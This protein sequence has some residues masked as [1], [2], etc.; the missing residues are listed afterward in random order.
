MHYLLLASDYFPLTTST[1]YLLPNPAHPCDYY[2]RHHR[3]ELFTTQP[4]HPPVT[5]TT[6]TARRVHSA[7]STVEGLGLFATAAIPA[8]TLVTLY[9]VHALGDEERALT[10]RSEADVFGE[11]CTKANRMVPSHSSLRVW[12]DDLWID[13][14]HI[15]H[16]LTRREN[17]NL[18]TGAYVSIADIACGWCDR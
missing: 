17:T 5:T 6:P 8:A 9:P 1:Y 3:Q 11:A 16:P 15:T 12:A 18:I 13:V 4:H 2:I 7:P 14:R 10:L